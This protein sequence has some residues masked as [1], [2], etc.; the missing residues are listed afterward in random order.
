MRVSHLENLPSRG[1][2]DPLDHESRSALVSG[3]G[4]GIGRATA[5]V[6]AESGYAVALVGR[7]PDPLNL[8]VDEITARGGRA[9]SI[10]ADVS[11]PEGSDSAIAVA[12]D[13]FGR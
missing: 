9:L 2:E 7:R 4:T 3:A 13:A 11:T 1:L 8:V 5:L 6:L 10:S 12:L